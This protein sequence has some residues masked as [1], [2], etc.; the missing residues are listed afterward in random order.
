MLEIQESIAV[1]L[2]LHATDVGTLL[3]MEANAPDQRQLKA[4][5]TFTPTKFLCIVKSK[6]SVKTFRLD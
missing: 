5:C 3:S 4:S 6:V 2:N 1:L